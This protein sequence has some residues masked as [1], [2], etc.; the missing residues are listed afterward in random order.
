MNKFLEYLDIAAKAAVVAGKATGNAP[1]MLGGSILD[2]LIKSEHS[3]KEM[4][5]ELE[6]D[7]IRELIEDAKEVLD[8]RAK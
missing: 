3:N 2:A 4:L 6:D 1:A 8:K 7:Q 5:E